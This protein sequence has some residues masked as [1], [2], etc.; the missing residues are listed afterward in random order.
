MTSPTHAAAPSIVVPCPFC[1]T[2]NRVDA[3]RVA[4][5]PKCGSAE[6][7]KPLLLDRPVA[8][9]DGDFSAVI[10]GTEV[11]VLVDFHADW[12]APC[13]MMAPI[14][15]ELAHRRA[16]ALLV[17]KVDTDH[18][19]ATAQRY[20]VSSIPTLILFS[21]GALVAQRSG[22]MSA[23]ALSQWLHGLGVPA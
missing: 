23:N 6:C 2:V 17:G 4:D 10:A 15:N 12:C 7:R 3:T 11:P 1:R 20:H 22:A 19:I 18:E 8:L 14:L 16:G 21:G 13:R 5:R 9:H